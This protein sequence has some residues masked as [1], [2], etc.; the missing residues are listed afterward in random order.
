MAGHRREQRLRPAMTE[1]LLERG[2]RVAATVRK[3]DAL[4]DLVS[5]Y[6]DA[7]WIDLLDLSDCKAVRSAVNRA[8]DRLGRIDVVVSNAG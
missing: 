8:F 1:L 5:R 7:L 2:D 3:P 6:G 4:G